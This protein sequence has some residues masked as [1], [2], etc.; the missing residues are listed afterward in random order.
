MGWEFEVKFGNDILELYFPTITM[1][2]LLRKV[3]EI[4][5]IFKVRKRM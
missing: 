1:G 2:N 5:E 3:Q 4:F